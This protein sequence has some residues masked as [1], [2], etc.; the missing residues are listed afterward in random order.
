MNLRR[1][2]RGPITWLIVAVIL[3]L[4]LLTITSSTGG[5]KSVSLSTIESAIRDGK[6][7]T[8]TLQDKE[9]QIQVTL[10]SGDEIQKSSKLQSSYTIHYDDALY[11]ELAD[12]GVAERK[13][14]VSH[15]N[16]FLSI[17]FNLIPF[18]LILLIM[19]FF[20]NQMQG[21]GGRVMQFG[22]AR[23]KLVSKDTPKT[24]F[25]DVAGA[26]EAIEE[27]QEIKEFLENP[28]KFQAIGAKIP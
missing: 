16:P 11:Q 18:A 8:A 27:L 21:G 15:D 23:A 24:T 19:F 1:T 14:K 5:Y 7:A 13:V 2:I 22:K 26:D 4:A 17:L 9:Q 10:K 3:V 6:V 12:A 20:L 28:A 25:A